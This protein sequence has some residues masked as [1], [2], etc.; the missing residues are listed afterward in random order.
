MKLVLF[1]PNERITCPDNKHASLGI[2]RVLT[3]PGDRGKGLGFSSSA[4]L[5]KLYYTRKNKM[6]AKKKDL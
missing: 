1:S 5:L 6:M 4:F 3:F 2:E